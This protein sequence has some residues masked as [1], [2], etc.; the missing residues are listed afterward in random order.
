[1][2]H[3]LSSREKSNKIDV[4]FLQT[5]NTEEYKTSRIDVNKMYLIKFIMESCAILK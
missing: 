1:M 3:V 2:W 5:R 4:L